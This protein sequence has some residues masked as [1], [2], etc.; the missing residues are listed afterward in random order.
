M[1]QRWPNTA[2]QDVTAATLFTSAFGLDQGPPAPPLPLQPPSSGKLLLPDRVGFIGFYF[3]NR[4]DFVDA[5]NFSVQREFSRDLAVEL[6][7]VG[8]VGRRLFWND[9]INAP[10]PG[11]GSVNPRR[12]YFARYGWTQDITMRG[13]EGR[14]SYNSLQTKAEKRFSRGQS[15]IAAFTWQKA[16]DFGGSSPQNVF[17]WRNDHGPGDNDRAVFASIS[18]IW[19]LPFNVKGPA[20]LLVNGWNF[21]GIAFFASGRPFTPTL[22]NTASLNSFGVTLRPDRLGSGASTNPTRDRWFEPNAFAVPALYTYGN[23]GRNILRG[24][25]IANVDWSLGKDFGITESMKLKFR[26][27]AY[28]IFNRTNL[29]PPVGTVDTATAGRILGLF[30]GY[31]MRR[32]QFGL[33]LVW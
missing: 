21:D 9:S 2:S 28:N 22:G 13:H 4:F 25:G 12:P 29:G 17:N 5:W 8:N 26:A 18:H 19:E 6:S 16:M 30:P 14:N 7:Y 3:D 11:P 31:N 23:S 20:G 1:S 32:M 27:E 24:P 15:V 33:H 10:I